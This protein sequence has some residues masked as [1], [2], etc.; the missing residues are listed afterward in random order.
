MFRRIEVG[1]WLL[2]VDKERTA[3][4]Y[5]DLSLISEEC[6][7]SYCL[8]YVSAYPHFPPA[9]KDF[10]EQ[11]GIDPRKE[12]EVYQLYQYQ[13]G[14]EPMY[15]YAGFYHFVGCI[16]QNPS[17]SNFMTEESNTSGLNFTVFGDFEVNFNTRNELV[18]KGFPEPVVQM[19]FQDLSLPWL[20][21]LPANELFM[22]LRPG[23]IN[24]E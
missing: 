6:P 22:K 16:L 13:D 23:K 9:I 20:F 17:D 18:P 10:F 2:E 4:T 1:G 14:S 15:V 12:G 5:R 7:C 19:E 24:P 11:F 8:N 3:A 21:D